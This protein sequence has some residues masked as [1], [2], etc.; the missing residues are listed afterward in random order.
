MSAVKKQSPQLEATPVPERTHPRIQEDSTLRRLM[1]AEVGETVSNTERHGAELLTFAEA[2]VLKTKMANVISG[3][4]SK[5][6]QKIDHADKTF[7]YSVGHF[8][9]SNGD[10]LICCAA[11]RTA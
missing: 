6:R 9:A 3:Q 2:Q 7:T 1:R 11:T 10:V 4:I 8:T 5:V